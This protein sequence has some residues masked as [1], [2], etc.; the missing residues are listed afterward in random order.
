MKEM[1]VKKKV[2]NGYDSGHVA[3]FLGIGRGTVCR[4]SGRHR[5]GK[6]QHVISSQDL[7]QR[8]TICRPQKAA[9]R[10]EPGV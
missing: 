4:R 9:D 1:I 7:D 3:R 8:A 5:T 10:A 6:D 2:F